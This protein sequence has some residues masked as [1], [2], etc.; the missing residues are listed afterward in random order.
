MSAAPGT[1]LPA[2]RRTLGPYR[3][4]DYDRLPEQPRHELLEGRLVLMPSP[5]LRHQAVVL[6]LWKYLQRTTRKGRGWVVAAPADVVLAEH[7]V[8]QPDIYYVSS[9]R[10]DMPL[11]G[12]RVGAPDLVVE[13]LSPG[14]AERD[15]G[16]KARLYAET[17]VREYWIVDPAERA[18]EFLANDGGVFRPALPVDRAFVST[19]PGVR[20][21]P[22]EF[23]QE[24]DDELS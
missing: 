10:K 19:V 22:A 3:L 13:V 16:L 18:F 24:L 9:D 14:T 15:R 21:D 4:A 17:G 6:F 11:D 8:V 23:W 7:T 2:S 12:R 5:S 20:I 1:G